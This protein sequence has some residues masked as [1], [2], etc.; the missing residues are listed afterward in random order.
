[1]TCKKNTTLK[2]WTPQLCCNKT[3]SK[4]GGECLKFKCYVNNPSG[5]DIQ[6]II[7]GEIVEGD[8]LGQNY[9]INTKDNGP[10]G[11]AFLCRS[12]IKNN[13]VNVYIIVDKI[14]LKDETKIN[15]TDNKCEYVVKLEI[16]SA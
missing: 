5:L 11:D 10:I 13:T 1:M 6:V 7:G 16:P 9:V 4:C 2:N 8:T 12:T 3:T 15:I 14:F